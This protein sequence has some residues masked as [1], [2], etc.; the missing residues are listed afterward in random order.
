MTKFPLVPTRGLSILSTLLVIIFF[1]IFNNRNKERN[2]RLI[3]YYSLVSLISDGCFSAFPK[4]TFYTFSFFTIIEFTL[5]STFFYFIYYSKNL[6]KFIILSLPLFY[7]LAIYNLFNQNKNESNFDSLTAAIESILL[8]ICSIL[9]FYEELNNPKI[10]FI[11]SSKK[12]WIVV[13][14]LMY[15]SA[16]LFLFIA[17]SLITKG[18]F[19]RLLLINNSANILKNILFAIAINMYPTIKSTVPNSGKYRI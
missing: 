6:K 12:F 2:L 1:L 5:F 10:N 8:I 16:A 14:I 3:F 15:L 17:A 13:G 18:D 9:Y 19:K 11:Y 4:A 7:S